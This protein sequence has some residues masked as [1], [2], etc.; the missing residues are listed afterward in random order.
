MT[1]LNYLL[2]LI[3][4]MYGTTVSI[5]AIFFRRRY[6]KNVRGPL[7]HTSIYNSKENV[8][9]G[10][11]TSEDEASPAPSSTVST[12]NGSKSD[13]M[14][15]KYHVDAILYG[16]DE[17]CT[18]LTVPH[19]L[20][21]HKSCHQTKTYHHAILHEN[22]LPKVI[23]ETVT[24]PSQNELGLFFK[25][26]WLCSCITFNLTALTVVIYWV[27]MF[28]YQEVEVSPIRWY[29]RVDRHAVVFLFMII[30]HMI[31]RIPVRILHFV[32]P[33]MIFL[34]YGLVNALYTVLTK[35][36]IYEM[37]NFN[38]NTVTSTVYVVGASFVATPLMQLIIYW[39]VYRLR[40]RL[41]SSY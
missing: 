25:L 37:L 29:L 1:S 28:K 38:I 21:I 40:E 32:Y 13:L 16:F 6:Y 39:T 20:H 5:Y 12:L 36:F 31:S 23:I 27:M 3:Y 11:L 18:K 7:M 2:V 26:Y 14:D 10:M 8:V 4:F 22:Q 24:D 35:D 17:K 30:D 15:H 19:V 41:F 9:M 33:S 34:L